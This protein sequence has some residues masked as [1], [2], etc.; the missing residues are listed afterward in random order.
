MK[1]NSINIENNLHLKKNVFDV[2]D[3]F[4]ETF[5]LKC[6]EKIYTK[7]EALQLPENYFEENQLFL[8]VITH[9]KQNP[10]EISGQYFDNNYAKLA[11]KISTPNARSITPKI[12][13]LFRSRNL[14]AAAVLTGILFLG[15]YIF[16]STEKTRDVKDLPCQTL[17]C[18]SKKD[19]LEK[20]EWLD[21]QTI[22]E[23]LDDI[24]GN[25]E[26]NFSPDNF[27][28]DSVSKK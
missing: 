9:K 8:R 7:K 10:F 21:D 1:P 16:R 4:F 11:S 12:Y 28:D 20:P 15:I 18:L 25:I 17:A 23:A 19:L 13:S 2:P 6:L 5:T 26:N 14:A 27:S 22:E 24:S 3:D